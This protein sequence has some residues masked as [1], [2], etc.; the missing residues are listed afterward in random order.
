M[1][2]GSGPGYTRTIRRSSRIPSRDGKG[3]ET[4]HHA[5]EQ[6]NELQLLCKEISS[7]TTK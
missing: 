3:G 1:V 6:E 5:N 7:D 4:K 2:A